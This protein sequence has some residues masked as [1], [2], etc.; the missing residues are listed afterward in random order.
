[1]TL[2]AEPKKVA[3]LGALLAVAGIA[4]YMNTGDE[5]PPASRRV[6]SPPVAGVNTNLTKATNAPRTRGGNRVA[7]S[8]FHPRLGSARPE[9]KIDPALIEPELRLDLLAKVEAVEPMAAGRNLFQFGTA[10]ASPVK[11][12]P[13]PTGVPPIAVN[14]PPPPPPQP[15]VTGPPPTPQAQPIPLKY[16]GY[17]VWKSDGHK[18]AYLNDGEEILHAGENE[19]LKQRYRIVSIS[20]KSIVIEDTQQKSTQTLPLVEPPA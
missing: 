8:E 13:V 15:V 1:M 16:Y 11:L 18:I 7:S 2:G 12:P 10:S 19:T 9:D 5:S 14:H 3:I 6:A 4:I 20:L 17:K